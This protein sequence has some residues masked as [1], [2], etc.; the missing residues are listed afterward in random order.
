MN[1]TEKALA[2]LEAA[3]EKAIDGI[4][5][6]ANVEAQKLMVAVQE[7]GEWTPDGEYWCL[8]SDY[9]VMGDVRHNAGRAKQRAVRGELYRT[10]SE[11]GNA[12]QRRLAYRRIVKLIKK[13]S[14]GDKRDSYILLN[15]QSNWLQVSTPPGFTSVPSELVGHFDAIRTVMNQHGSDYRLAMGWPEVGE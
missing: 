13:L 4:K 14:S 7:P 11:A 6:V 10:E 9:V 12:D 15:E 5:L 2:M 3:T 1:D 8:S